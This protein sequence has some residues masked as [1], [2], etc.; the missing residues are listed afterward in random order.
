[1]TQER[2]GRVRE[3]LA[4][5]L[6]QPAAERSAFLDEACGDDRPMRAEVASLLRACD[7]MGD[8]LDEPAI[9]SLSEIWPGQSALAH[10]DRVGGYE[11]I[12]AIGAGG[13]GTVFEALQESP[14]RRVA[15]KVMRGD[16]PS[17]AAEQRFRNEA[18]ILARLRHSAVAHVY[19]AGVHAVAGST[20]PWFAMEFVEG[21]RTVVAFAEEEGL[22]RA[23]R[24]RLVVQVCD[25]L[26]HAH[27][28]GIIHRDLKPGN[29]VV[30]EAG[31]PKVIDFGIARSLGP[32]GREVEIA[33]TLAYMSPEQ[34][35]TDAQDVDV[36]TDVYALGVLLF[37][38]LT[39]RLPLDVTN[40]PVD[41]AMLRIREESPTAIGDLDPRLRGDVEAIVDKALRKD[42]G[43]R[44]A[45]AAA[46]ADDLR[47]HLGHRPVE[48]RAAG[49][50]YQLGRLARRHRAV[51][52]GLAA[53]VLVS[54]VGAIVAGRLAVV[55]S[56][57]L[58]EKEDERRSVER[59]RRVAVREAYIANVAA[60]AGALDVGDVG[61]ARACLARA[62]EYL[63]G[64]EWRNL[65]HR[66]DMSATVLAW[67]GG[68]ISGGAVSAD[69]SR[70]ACLG[71]IGHGH[72]L[73]R[74]WDART[75]EVATTIDL[76]MPVADCLALGPAARRLASG[77]RDGRVQIRSV[78]TGEVLRAFDAHAEDVI[79]MSFSAD[80]DLLATASRDRTAG[81]WNTGSGTLRWRLRGH[82]DRVIGLAFSPSGRTLATAGRGGDIR[83][84]NIATGE[85]TGRLLG[86][87]G[88]VEDV[89]FSPDGARL[90]SGSR[91][92]TVR[93]WDIERR[94][95]RLVC[96]G[97]GDNVRSVT[98]TLDGR[99]VA[100]ASY[101]RTVRLWDV[102]TGRCLA[103]LRGHSHLIRTVRSLRNGSG[104]GTLVSFSADGTVRTWPPVASEPVPALR[105]HEQEVT[106]LAF[107]PRSEHLASASADGAVRLWDV[108]RRA[109][110]GT[111]AGP[112]GIV[113]DVAFAPDGS[114]VA[115]AFAN[116]VVRWWSVPDGEPARRAAG[117][118]MSAVAFDLRRERALVAYRS[119]VTIRDL[120][121]SPG[122]PSE[123][124]YDSRVRTL[125]LDPS[126]QRLGVGLESGSTML[127]DLEIGHDLADAGWAREE[128]IA[129]AF[130]PKGRFLARA[131]RGVIHLLDART[132]EEIAP[133]EGGAM[134][135][136]DL[137]FFPGGER[138]AAACL[139]GMV[140]L[141]DVES[142]RQVA[143]LRRRGRP[144]FSVAVSPDGRCLAAGDG[145][146]E[147]PGI[148]HLYRQGGEGE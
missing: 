74:I 110:L 46:L 138:L 84:W 33:G 109:S 82:D 99:F 93:I 57:L 51:V 98:F 79:A 141:W 1:M 8:F 96:R 40:E 66:A 21:A 38:V 12:R 41:R 55:R 45:S 5:A 78:P 133:L 64:W 37:E 88:S 32:G 54:L 107:G 10:G 115:A 28:R 120:R 90:V 117:P 83:L 116:G 122:D 22:G 73:A 129:L 56:R 14:R 148:I 31:Q 59:H 3:I 13:S 134:Q 9:A 30:D 104:A 69:G 11:I 136:M 65:S 86:H 108:R 2:I 43:E 101:D 132:L 71:S 67:P 146:T 39:G 80:G 126:G 145:L 35:S 100:S 142:R 50:L 94:E 87:D 24:L 70:L 147:V 63:R 26:H 48:A 27:Q 95:S 15:L 139:D 121:A 128:I 92:G 97:H 143:V 123:M 130:D 118:P 34:W 119:M 49:L 102:G 103:I 58:L 106:V 4:R 105:G 91:D 112:G 23:D 29:V 18:E 114:R 36:R 7:A 85:E 52:A 44:Y 124:A 20:L 89:A 16:L 125:A 53:V 47:R 81:I 113:R 19:E 6:E 140:R 76:G 68:R 60:A 111:L 42:R 72:S 131:A 25:A 127:R 137:V 144:F 17:Q 135:V 62:P 61:E 75:R 77:R